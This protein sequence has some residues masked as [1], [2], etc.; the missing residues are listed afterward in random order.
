[1]VGTKEEGAG[2]LQSHRCCCSGRMCSGSSGCRAFLASDISVRASSWSL[3]NHGFGSH[4]FPARGSRRNIPQRAQAACRRHHP[5][6]E[7]YQT[8]RNSISRLLLLPA[9]SCAW[10]GLRQLLALRGERARRGGHGEEVRSW[11]SWPRGVV[12]GG[13]PGF[14]LAKAPSGLWCIG[15]MAWPL[16]REPKARRAWSLVC[17]LAHPSFDLPGDTALSLWLVMSPDVPLAC[18]AWPRHGGGSG[19]GGRGP[20]PWSLGS[21]LTPRAEVPRLGGSGGGA[22][23]GDVQLWGSP[24]V[25]G[26]VGLV[27]LRSCHGRFSKQE[28]SQGSFFFPR[29]GLQPQP[30]CC[31]NRWRWFRP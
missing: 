29:Q 23:L 22:G 17:P 15:S 21:F 5:P 24:R 31:R 6:A 16:W 9:P 2:L 8:L 26:V 18:S 19:R 25:D 20:C 10:Q 28:S 11:Q 3:H 13:N 30:G 4:P 7:L 1:M 27:P 14:H 12:H